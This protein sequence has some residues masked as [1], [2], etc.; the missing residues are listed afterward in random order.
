MKQF[1]KITKFNKQYDRFEIYAYFYGTEK[2]VNDYC[3]DIQAEYECEVNYYKL[4]VVEG[5]LL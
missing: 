3:D 5:D 4:I 2:Q 1:Y